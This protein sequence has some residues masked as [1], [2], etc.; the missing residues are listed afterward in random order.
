MLTHDSVSHALRLALEKRLLLSPRERPE[1][2]LGFF[3][4]KTHQ[5]AGARK[6]LFSELADNDELI[7]NF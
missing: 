7:I 2:P 3:P 6:Q 5:Y 4:T 1:G